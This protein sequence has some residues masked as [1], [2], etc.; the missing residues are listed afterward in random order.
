M[1]VQLPRAGVSETVDSELDFEIRTRKGSLN[2]AETLD[3][4]EQGLS[5]Q[6]ISLERAHES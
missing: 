1:E 2:S 5:D 4:T 6:Q 3:S